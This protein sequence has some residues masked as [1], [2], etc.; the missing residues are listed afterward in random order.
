MGLDSIMHRGVATMT[1]ATVLVSPLAVLSAS[2][3]A[4]Q[5]PGDDGRLAVVRTGPGSGVWTFEPSG[6]DQLLVWAGEDVRY[7]EW[8]PDGRRLAVSAT[9]SEAEPGLHARQI[10]TAA[11]DG[12][13][14]RRVTASPD[15][16]YD[17]TWSPDGRSIAF[18]TR[19]DDLRVVDLHDGGPDR[20][21][22][23]TGCLDDVA[24]SPDGST[25][26]YTHCAFLPDDQGSTAD[27]WSVPAEGGTPTRI[28]ST[29]EQERGLD[30]SPDG[31]QLVVSG[32]N[33]D[34]VDS[35]LWLMGTDGSSRERLLDRRDTVDPVFSPRGDRLAVVTTPLDRPWA[36]PRVH[37]VDLATNDVTEVPGPLADADLEYTVS[38][39]R[40]VPAVPA[41]PGDLTAEVTG[42]ETVSTG[43]TATAEAP[44]QTAIAV[45]AGVSGTLAV[46]AQPAGAPPAGFSLFGQQVVLTGPE[47]TTAAPY[48]VSFLVDESALGGVAPDDVQVWRNGA[49]V[50]GCTSPDAAVPD[51]C[52]ASRG[53]TPEAG[54][55]GDAAVTVRTSRFSTWTLGAV[56]YDLTGPTAPVDAYPVVN[57]TKAGSAV[58]VK[59]RLGGDRGLDVLAAGYPRTV[60][61]TC[62]GGSDEV[63]TTVAAGSSALRYD[64]ASATYTYTWKT[65]RSARGC[66]DL[67]LR[68]RD[69]SELRARFGLR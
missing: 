4:A 67:V 11:A 9:D 30:V 64:A 32:R 27:I 22:V 66:T 60:S 56:D 15:G 61:A 36:G 18:T 54:D 19:T 14:R 65:A 34:G 2:P 10:W 16:A 45:P 62:S 3:A 48:V 57:T 69:G 47:A 50:P 49:L 26:Y 20:L 7:P 12:S 52:V 55:G 35:Y 63:E 37:L 68:F 21:L 8:S 59:F 41:E 1:A 51:P 25:I 43:T 42:G 28:T 5:V 40:V 33:A 6:G 53:S 13:D 38:W 24:W 31:Q 44:V 23:D 58:P 29:A 17:L 46:D 39:Q